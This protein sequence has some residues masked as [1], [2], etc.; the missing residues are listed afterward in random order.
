MKNEG[1]F[2]LTAYSPPAVQDGKTLQQVKSVYTTAVAVQKPRNIQD[3]LKRCEEE[4]IIAGDDFYYAWSVTSRGKKG[5]KPKKVLVEGP[6]IGL[7]LAAARHYGNNVVDVEVEETANTYV[8][9]A[10]FVDLETG[11]NF[12]RLFRQNKT[13]SMGRYDEDRAEDI[14][15]QIGQSKAIRNVILNALPVT[16]INRMMERAKENVIERIKKKGLN[17]A[18]EDT[19]EFFKKY[20]IDVPRIE[21]KLDIPQD[22]WKVDDL[23]KL[24]GAIKAIVNDQESADEL[25]PPLSPAYNVSPE[26]LEEIEILFDSLNVN[27]ATRSMRLGKCKNDKDAQKLK[28]ELASEALKKD[29]EKGDKQGE[30]GKADTS[31]ASA[32]K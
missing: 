3:A 28:D 19:I 25:F 8:F 17:K 18:K 32:H 9:K 22:K 16:L 31:G 2:P 23:A 5:S 26:I 21:A 11:S 29:E 14:V 27:E 6:S 1:E 4:A 13:R 7:A 30:L 24:Y 20:G 10:V 15:F 12:V